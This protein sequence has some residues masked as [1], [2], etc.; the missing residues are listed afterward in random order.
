MFEK[1]NTV[2]QNCCDCNVDCNVN[3]NAPAADQNEKEVQGEKNDLNTENRVCEKTPEEKIKELEEIIQKKEL[4]IAE[5]KNKWI[6]TQADFDNYR[7]RVQREIS[8]IHLYAGEQLI[9]DILPVLDNFELAIKSAADK[10]DPFFEGVEMIYRQ[11]IDVLEKQNVKEIDA[12][13]KTFDPKFHEAVMQVETE[14]V[15]P[16]TIVEVL[17]KGYLYHSK[18]IRPSM[19]KVATK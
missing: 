7:K 15:E 17:K 5:Y 8:D 9:K 4:E 11:L 16:N 2:E 12:Y 6:R 3:E 10:S 13:G 19:V 14:D 18:V 1:E